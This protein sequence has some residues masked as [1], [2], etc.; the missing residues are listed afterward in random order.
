M[1]F[2]IFLSQLQSWLKSLPEFPGLCLLATVT[3]VAKRQ[4][5]NLLGMSIGLHAGLIW[6]YYIVNVGNLVK[7]T[8]RVPDWITGINGNPISGIHGIIFLTILIIGL[9]KFLPKIN[10]KA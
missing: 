6:A 3:I 2:Y 8:D 4:N 7:Y 1:H 10:I 5:G 9:A